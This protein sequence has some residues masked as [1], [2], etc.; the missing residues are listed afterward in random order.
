MRFG[1]LFTGIGGLDLGLERAGMECAWQV[2]IDE[3]CQKVLTKH[4]PDVPK[5]G[6]IRDVGKE[7]LETV[8]L[9]CGGFPCQPFSVAGKQR[10]TADDRHLWPEMLRVISE[11]KPAWVLGENV[12]GII[13][14]FLD[15]AIA[16]LEAEGYTCEAFVLPAVGFDAPHKRQR[17]F[18][19]S[20]SNDIRRILIKAKIQSAKRGV[21]AQRYA[22]PVFM[23]NSKRQGLQRENNFQEPAIFTKPSRWLPEPGVGRVASRISSALDG[24]V[25]RFG[26]ENTDSEKAIT[27]IDKFRGEILRNMWYQ[28]REI[29]P[30]PYKEESGC[31]NDSLYEMSCLRTHERWNLGQRIEKEKEL[32]DLWERICAKPFEKTYNLQRNM[33][34]Q[35]RAQERNEK[36]A[37]SRVDRLRGLG[38]AVVPQVAEFIGQIIMEANND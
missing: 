11:L 31:D 25:R 5:Y 22:S 35:I 33:L 6:D 2:E 19:I 14:I 38:N 4:W 23:G 10:G 7:N 27:E 9:I 16:D 8:D 37:S 20:Y 21:N 15:Q 29:E 36:V 1:S 18:V 34:E 26:Y 3:W 12:P 32:C 13:P 30:P 17:L 28:E 24:T